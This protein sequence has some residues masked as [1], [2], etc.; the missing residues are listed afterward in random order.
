MSKE[1]RKLEWNQ[2]IDELERAARIRLE[3]IDKPDGNYIKKLYVPNKSW[4]PT[5]EL[6][7]ELK[8]WFR[9]ARETLPGEQKFRNNLSF[10]QRQLLLRIKTDFK[11]TIIKFICFDNSLWKARLIIST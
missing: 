6:P 10:S 3:F 1:S 5:A 7:Q 2:S 8:N 11:L 4:Q 9:K